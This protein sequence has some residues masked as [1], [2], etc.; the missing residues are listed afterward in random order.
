M[1]FSRAIAQVEHI[2]ALG[3]HEVWLD[4]SST[5][6]PWSYVT[7]VEPGGCVRMDIN[8]SLRFSA[9]HPSGLIFHWLFDI[10]S[11]D[12]NGSCTYKIDVA[13]CTR[14]MELIPGPVKSQFAIIFKHNARVVKKKADE[15]FK[16]A[17]EQK[18]QSVVMEGLANYEKHIS[19]NKVRESKAGRKVGS[20]SRRRS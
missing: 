11:R 18:S 5:D 20:K 3:D 15:F 8:V 9:R 19:C 14:V 16:A 10:E 4:S 1:S 12:A 13:A 2:K 7:E 17:A 6:L